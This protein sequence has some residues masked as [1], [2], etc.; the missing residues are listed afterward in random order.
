MY[1]FKKKEIDSNIFVGDKNAKISKYGLPN[2]VKYCKK[3]LTSNQ[4][5]TTRSEQRIKKLDQDIQ[6]KTLK[7]FDDNI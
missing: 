1:Y 5:A 4:R 7:F 3:C 2:D 6:D